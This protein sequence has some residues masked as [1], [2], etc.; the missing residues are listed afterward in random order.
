VSRNA[1]HAQMRPRGRP[2]RAAARKAILEATL[3]LLAERGFQEATMDAIA[4]EA[5]VG[6][7]TIYRRW[8]SKEELIV[9]ALHELTAELDHL[10]GDDAYALLLEV[11]RDFARVFADPLVGRILPGLLGELQRNPEFAVLYADRVVRPRR[12][13]VVELLERALEHGELR[14]DADPDQIADLLIGP[15]FLRLL[16]PFGLPEVREHYVEELLETIWRG[17][18]PAD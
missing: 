12:E 6:K 10:D 5:G 18:A 9:D 4:A 13:V 11:I 8:A 7:N 17:I 2:R 15:T 14:D 1:T 3:Q 16:L